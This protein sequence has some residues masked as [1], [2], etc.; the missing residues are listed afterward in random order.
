MDATR[1]REGLDPHHQRREPKF[2]YDYSLYAAVGRAV[3]R[4]N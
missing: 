2:R 1:A 4:R 3:C